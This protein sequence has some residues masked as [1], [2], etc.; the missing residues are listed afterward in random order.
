MSELYSGVSSLLPPKWDEVEL[1]SS[2][3]SASAFT[4][5]AISLPLWSCGLPHWSLNIVICSLLFKPKALPL[6]YP[7]IP[8]GW[9]WWGVGFSLC[10][11]H[12]DSL[13]L[14]LPASSQ[15]AGRVTLIPD[16]NPSPLDQMQ[17]LCV[18][19]HFGLQTPRQL[20]S[21]KTSWCMWVLSGYF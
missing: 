10:S 2:S 18:D 15:H 7:L 3:L 8:C 12:P 19:Q 17:E 6:P 11:C 1:R 5:W 14:S 20:T 4:L 13:L 16:H 21:I 9:G